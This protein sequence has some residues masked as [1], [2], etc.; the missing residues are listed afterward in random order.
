MPVDFNEL[1][2]GERTR[3]LRELPKG[4]EVFCSAGCAGAWY[5]DWVADNY[6]P[7]GKH[8]GIELY[9]PKPDKLP[10]NV[11]WIE[12][13]VS[14]MTDVSSDSVDLLFSGQN[15]EHLYYND[16][17]G[18][19]REASRVLKTGGHLCIDSPNR[20]VTEETGYIQPQH[21]L[22]FSR[23]DVLRMVEAA[24]FEVTAAHGIWSSLE[25][26]RQVADITATADENDARAKAARNDPDASFIWW[27]VARKVGEPRS[28]L[29]ETIEKIVA[30]RFSPFVASRFRKGIGTVGSI[31]GT[32]TIIAVEPELHGPVFF[33][34]YVPLTEG[35]YV[36][37]A[38]VKFLAPE[39]AVSLAVTTDAGQKRIAYRFVDATED[40]V[41]EW[42]TIDLPFDIDAYAEGVETPLLTHGAKALVRLGS[43]ILRR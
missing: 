25:D 15:L 21:V 2:H 40:E 32:E 12:N 35:G 34:P 31:E 9:L 13:S 38:Q 3:L 24:G 14:D 17:Q 10:D 37:Q 42:L 4:A 8:I 7:V 1:I 22:E 16:I 27:V 5:F 19:F 6:G 26:D 11:V 39:G 33:G 29:A 36:A 41:G 30:Q 18:F 43:Q 28:D 23:E 20:L